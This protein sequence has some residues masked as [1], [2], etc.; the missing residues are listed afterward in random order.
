[1]HGVQLPRLSGSELDEVVAQRGGSCGSCSC[2]ASAALAEPIAPG[3]R[4]T[5]PTTSAVESTTQCITAPCRS[6]M[7]RLMQSVQEIG[8]VPA[9]PSTRCTN[10]SWLPESAVR[11]TS[12]TLLVSALQPRVVPLRCQ[13]VVELAQLGAGELVDPGTRVDHDREWGDRD[14]PVPQVRVGDRLAGVVVGHGQLYPGRLRGAGL[15]VGPTALDQLDDGLVGAVAGDVD[16]RVGA[17]GV[18][19]AGEFGDHRLQRGRPRQR[20]RRSGR[21]VSCTS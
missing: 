18:I 8:A 3:V 10:A 12:T 6:G 21:S 7:S 16:Q 20:Q 11:L 13:P 5:L 17:G 2:W 9:R 15:L 1:M 14:R 19:V 4:A